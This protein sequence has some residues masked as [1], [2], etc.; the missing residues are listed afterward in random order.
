[1]TT[2]KPNFLN[3]RLYCHG[4]RRI[5][6]W[7]LPWLKMRYRRWITRRRAMVVIGPKLRAVLQKF[8]ISGC[9]FKYTRPLTS[10]RAIAWRK[11]LTALFES[12]KGNFGL[13]RTPTLH[14]VSLKLCWCKL[15]EWTE[16]SKLY[17]EPNSNELYDNMST[18]CLL[19]PS[20]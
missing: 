20:R 13:Q 17:Y 9:K 6:I 4:F 2:S 1:M 12:V 15:Y 5:R 7:T 3:I 16:Q 10:S 8:L 14:T 18:V 19:K 11:V